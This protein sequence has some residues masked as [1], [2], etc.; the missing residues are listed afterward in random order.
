MNEKGKLCR[1]KRSIAN[2]VFSLILVFAM[3]ISNVQI[4][5]GAVSAVWAAES[6]TERSSEK[7]GTGIDSEC[8]AQQHLYDRAVFEQP[9]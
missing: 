1:K 7:A 4:I 3:V 2:R 9:R 5:P 8:S 6:E